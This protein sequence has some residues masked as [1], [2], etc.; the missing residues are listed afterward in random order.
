MS[1]EIQLR[2]AGRYFLAAA[3]GD[4]DEIKHQIG[5]RNVHIDWWD[6][7]NQSALT[8]AAA[9]GK[10]EVVKYLL[11]KG[12]SVNWESY[13]G[14]TPLSLAMAHGHKD[15]ENALRMKGATIGRRPTT[16]YEP[17][18]FYKYDSIR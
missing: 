6:L 18:V 12:A 9:C 17:A 5:S 10:L 2:N 14:T 13:E 7:S 4:L 15:V 3:G 16:T 8:H 11:E 1:K